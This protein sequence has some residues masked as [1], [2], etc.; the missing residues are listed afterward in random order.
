[1][2]LWRISADT[3]RYQA[4]DLSGR[5]AE[6]TGGRWNEVGLPVVYTATTRALACL[7]TMVHL[8][9]GGLPL[10]PVKA[11]IPVAFAWLFAQGVSELIKRIAIMR[12]DLAE[13]EDHGSFHDAALAAGTDEGTT[14]P[15]IRRE[16]DRA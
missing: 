8:N 2:I 9:A 15:A 6:T 10:W 16:D 5:G 7:E 14:G 1:M 12:G 4:D 11:L 13:T 3:R